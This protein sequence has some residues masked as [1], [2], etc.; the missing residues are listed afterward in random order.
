MSLRA[1]TLR[2]HLQLDET[3][4]DSIDSGDEEASA[5]DDKTKTSKYDNNDNHIDSFIIHYYCSYHQ[6][7]VVEDKVGRPQV[8]LG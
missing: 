3:F 8:S 6:S 7:T 2:K 5:K 4:A 1:D